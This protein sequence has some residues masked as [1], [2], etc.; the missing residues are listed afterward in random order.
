MARD[1]GTQTRGLSPGFLLGVAHDKRSWATG[2]WPPARRS[3]RRGN[4][5][6]GPA[7][8]AAKNSAVRKELFAED[9]LFASLMPSS[10][11]VD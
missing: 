5:M 8:R 11:A 6:L 10:R 4:S 7:R 3:C 1:L 9:W 2:G